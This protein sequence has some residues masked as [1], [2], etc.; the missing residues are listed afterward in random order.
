VRY[1][2]PVEFTIEV[3]N[4]IRDG[5]GDT[6]RKRYGAVDTPGRDRR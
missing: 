6:F 3:I 1:L 2:S 4:S 5:K